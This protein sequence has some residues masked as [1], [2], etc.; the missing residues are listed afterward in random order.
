MGGRIRF[1]KIY[2]ENFPVK[3]FNNGKQ[4]CKIKML[5]IKMSESGYDSAMQREL[6][7]TVLTLYD[8]PNKHYKEILEA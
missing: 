5:A 3:P 4:A 7:E 6:D 2:V 8:I 1:K